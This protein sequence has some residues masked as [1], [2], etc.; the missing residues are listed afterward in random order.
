MS[1]QYV[2]HFSRIDPLRKAWLERFDRPGIEGV[3]P[4]ES[5][6]NPQEFRKTEYYNDFLLPNDIVHQFCGPVVINAEWACNFTC[7]RSRI[8]GPFDV[9]AVSILRVLLPHLQRA[10][11]F[12][13]KYAGLEGKYH[14]SL[15]ALDRL[16]T[17]MVLVDHKGRIAAMNRAAQRILGLN[18]GLTADRNGLTA[19]ASKDAK[20]LKLSIAAAALTARSESLSAGACLRIIRPSGKRPFAI[21][22]M[23]SSWRAFPGSGRVAV[24]VFIA[25]PDARTEVIAEMLERLFD[26]TKAELRVAER[27]MRGDRLVDAAANL[28][29]SHNTARTHLQRIYEK[30]GTTHQSDLVRVLL[31]AA[32]RVLPQ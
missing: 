27:V 18:D 15:D 20:Q 30:T 16:P 13:H 3:V 17:G 23:P 29:I 8:K 6:I 19:S 32:G 21:T 4:S 5:L 22:V 12:H 24:I 28:G 2:Q 26:L 31:A 7:L 10:V 1:D 9:E 14:T 11:Q 25:D